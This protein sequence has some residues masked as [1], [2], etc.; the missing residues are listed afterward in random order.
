MS[1]IERR[2]IMDCRNCSYYDYQGDNTKGYCSYY[3][4]YYYPEEGR[5]CKHNTESISSNDSSGGC[6]VATCVYGSYDCPEVWVLR[7]YRDYYLANT[8][9]GRG[10]IKLYYAVSPRIV[11]VF[12]NRKSFKVFW[13]RILDKK[14]K[15]L[16]ELGVESTPYKDK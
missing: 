13:K 11:K 3:K 4:A 6:Y 15:K 16:H 1:T 12:G 14:V 7:R 5:G 9:F 2:N 10:F 8:M